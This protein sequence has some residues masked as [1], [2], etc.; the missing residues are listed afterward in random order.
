M[1]QRKQ[2][3][4]KVCLHWRAGVAGARGCPCF[5]RIWT[6]C[7][8]VPSSCTADLSFGASSPDTLPGNTCSR[9][10]MA[11]RAINVLPVLCPAL[12][13]GGEAVPCLHLP[14]SNY[15]VRMGGGQFRPSSGRGCVKLTLRL[16][17]NILKWKYAQIS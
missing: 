7:T 13:M 11:L 16:P 17:G 1:Q 5:T 3:L 10:A 14:R 2:A 4:L 8:S 15:H 9:S 12:A 6:S